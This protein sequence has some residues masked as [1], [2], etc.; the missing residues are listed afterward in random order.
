MCVCVVCIQGGRERVSWYVQVCVLQRT[1]VKS[2]FVAGD[3]GLKPD[4]PTDVA[5]TSAVRTLYSHSPKAK[6]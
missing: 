2:C 4:A 5:P 6:F 3:T 1:T